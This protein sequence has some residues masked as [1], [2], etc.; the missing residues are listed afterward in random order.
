M[1]KTNNILSEF[2]NHKSDAVNIECSEFEKLEKD[3][4]DYLK[5]TA[6]NQ[7]NKLPTA[8]EMLKS[9]G[10]D[11]NS[12]LSL[13]LCAKHMGEF[14]DLHTAPLREELEKLRADKESLLVR[15][16]EV[17]EINKQLEHEML[18]VKRNNKDL[19]AEN[20]RLKN[21]ISGYESSLKDYDVERKHLI[22][23]TKKLREVL[24]SALLF[25]DELKNHGI[26]NWSGETEA[27]K[28]LK[29]NGGVYEK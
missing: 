4:G 15:V 8:L 19:E 10:Y 9:V 13:E 29:A 21:I 26:T 28:A 7:E 14:L 27:K 22:N 11:K 24:E 5:L 17:R 3:F 16:E 2:A 12:G 18:L 23:Q 25:I 20:E 1:K 6:M